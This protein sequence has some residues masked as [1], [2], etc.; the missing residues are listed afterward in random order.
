MKYARRHREGVSER[1]IA[2][3]VRA[4]ACTR[5]Y[6][7]VQVR[8]LGGKTGVVATDGAR[9]H[10]NTIL[11]PTHP[12]PTSHTPPH[13]RTH[14]VQVCES[15]AQVFVHSGLVRVR[16]GPELW[17][18]NH[19]PILPTLTRTY[20]LTQTPTDTSDQRPPYTQRLHTL[21][22]Q[23]QVCEIDDHIFVQPGLVRVRGGPELWARNHTPTIPH[24]DARAHTHTHSNT[25][26]HIRPTPTN[27]RNTHTPGPGLRE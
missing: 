15:D 10:L 2:S 9:T 5:M 23:V 21:T 27:T 12:T 22:H 16:G 3:A 24:T 8:N 19:T 25:H 18:R 11:T 13:T 14:Q 26:R 1:A 20:T 4:C 17:V 6:I 7:Q